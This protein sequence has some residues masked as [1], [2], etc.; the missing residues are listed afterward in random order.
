MIAQSAKF[1]NRAVKIGGM[2]VCFVA[3]KIK[4]QSRCDF[5]SA[6]PTADS[7]KGCPYGIKIKYS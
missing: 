6:A 5:V 7:R 4:L 3:Q 1:G 2:L